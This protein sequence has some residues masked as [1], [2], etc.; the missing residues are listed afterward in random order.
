[1]LNE[2]VA[3]RL[4]DT[5]PLSCDFICLI[6][7]Y[8]EFISDQNIGGVGKRRRGNLRGVNLLPLSLEGLN[9]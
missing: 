9:V 3:K 6:I 8:V 4:A 5:V 2:Q 1:M 7:R